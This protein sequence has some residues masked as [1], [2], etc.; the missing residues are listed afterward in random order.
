MLSRS[1]RL[2]RRNK[3]K[4]ED[5]AV[6]LQK[7]IKDPAAEPPD[8]PKEEINDLGEG[9][10]AKP[11]NPPKEGNNDLDEWN[12]PSEYSIHLMIFFITFAVLLIYLWKGGVWDLLYLLRKTQPLFLRLRSL[13]QTLLDK[14]LVFS[15]YLVQTPAVFRKL[16]QD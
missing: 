11:P 10:A 15:R 12:T 1:E 14:L 2:E 7:E 16:L 8:S 9:S 6:N 4:E 5:S 13:P 3:M